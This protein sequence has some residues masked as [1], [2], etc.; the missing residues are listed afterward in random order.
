MQIGLRTQRNNKAAAAVIHGDAP[1]IAA[2]TTRYLPD[3]GQPQSVAGAV[4]AVAAAIEGREQLFELCRRRTRAVVP[5][6]QHRSVAFVLAT[7]T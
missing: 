2:V 6:L 7:C 1:G 4:V 5:H 3:Q